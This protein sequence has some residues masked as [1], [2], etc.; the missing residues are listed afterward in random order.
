MAKRT[1]LCSRPARAPAQQKAGGFF[2]ALSCRPAEAS[3][4]RENPFVGHGRAEIGPAVRLKLRPTELTFLLFVQPASDRPGEGIEIEI[5]LLLEPR[6]DEAADLEVLLDRRFNL[7]SA[8]PLGQGLDHERVQLGVLRLFH[9]VMLEQAFEL[10]VELPVVS[11]A[12][13]VM[14]LRHPLD[15]QNRDGY[16][17]RVMSQHALAISSG[18][19]MTAQGVPKPRSNS[20]RKR[21]NR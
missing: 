3:Q 20:S 4:R 17:Q 9:P 16:G 21:L 1:L 15:V 2:D 6:V 8:A 14:A 13:D 5:D 19:P 12:I 7:G 11:N 18:G 10:R